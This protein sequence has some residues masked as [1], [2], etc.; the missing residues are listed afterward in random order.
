VLAELP[1]TVHSCSWHDV[2]AARFTSERPG[3]AIPFPKTFNPLGEY[4]W[5]QA[6]WVCLKL[7]KNF[8]WC[9]RSTSSFT[10]LPLYSLYQPLAS[11]LVN[12]LHAQIYIYIY[13][14]IYIRSHIR[15]SY[16]C[17]HIITYLYTRILFR[18]FALRERC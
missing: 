5:H 8:C 9:V 10:S 18:L 14:Y 11:N 1:S 13:I 7:I 3:S 16:I 2:V 12:I 6:L 17:T 15:T 4:S